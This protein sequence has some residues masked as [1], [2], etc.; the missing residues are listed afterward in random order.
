MPDKE[1]EKKGFGPK[2]STVFGMFSFCTKTKTKFL[3]DLVT[4]GFNALKQSTGASCAL[5]YTLLSSLRDQ[6]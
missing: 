6:H 5:L 1:Q 3:T 2:T 4:D